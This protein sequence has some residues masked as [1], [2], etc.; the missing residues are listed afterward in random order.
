MANVDDGGGK[1]S[2]NVEVN[3]VPFIDLMSVLIIFLLISAVWTQVSMIQLGN[4]VYGKKTSEERPK[5]PP[6]ADVPFRLDIQE[7]GYR[8][9]LGKDFIPIPRVNKDFDN[10]ALTAE[11]VK[12]KELYNDKEDAIVTMDD[13]LE[14]KYLIDAM[15]TLIFNK[16]SQVTIAPGGAQ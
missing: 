4:S 7:T 9:L 2:T 1:K 5:P 10:E 13:S 15:D 3:I 12:I 16:F 6:K 8:I 11:L 14:Y